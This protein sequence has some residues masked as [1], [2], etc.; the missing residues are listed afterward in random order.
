MAATDAIQAAALE[1]DAGARVR[2]APPRRRSGFRIAPILATLVL[3]LHCLSSSGQV[4]SAES[5]RLPI[6]DT[7]K[8]VIDG[9]ELFEVAGTHSYPARRR[10]S[11][12]RARIIQIAKEHAVDASTVSVAPAEGR[13]RMTVAGKPLMDIFARDI[14]LDGGPDTI[15]PE[16]FAARVRESIQRY[17][18]A[19]EPRALLMSAGYTVAATLIATLLVWFLLR[20]FGWMLPV[21]RRHYLASEKVR[22][23]ESFR[24][25]RA[26]HLWRVI[27]AAASLVRIVL[28]ALVT[29]FYLEFALGRFPWTRGVALRLF[30]LVSEPLERMGQDFI[31]YIP[32][33]V[34]LFVL[35]VITR[36]LLRGI[37]LFFRAVARQQ[38]HLA[39]F[40]ADWA[41]PTYK[42][43]R[44]LVVALAAVI[45]YPYI[46]GSGSTAFQGISI[47]FGLIVSLGASSAV[48][49]IVAGYAMTYRRAFRIGD[50]VSIGEFTGVVTD[51]RVLVTHLRTF[52]NEE[53]VVPNSQILNSHVVNYSSLA[54][55]QPLRLHTTVGI[56][57]ETPWRQVEAMLKLAAA[58]TIDALEEPPPFVLERELGDF[59]VTY[60]VNV[61]FGSATR[62]VER[63]AELHR[64]ILDVFNEY[65][66]AIMTP[67]Y[68]GDP[69]QPK[70]VPRERWH[71]APA[72][73]DPDQGA[74]GEAIAEPG[75]HPR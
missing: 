14:E 22:R 20:L 52:W 65:G 3:G 31:E 45:A 4:A 29:L 44:V 60:E 16:L 38:I 66:V 51:M 33:L 63:R 42:L 70:V 40:D 48:S 7:D 1:T 5:E 74:Q 30:D 72:A 21:V 68:E 50:R 26:E 6:V 10:A 58:R 67:A 18:A 61:H 32:S 2:S 57:Y 17:R 71:A 56:G 64:H 59:A 36:Y 54:R 9:D 15:V 62:F 75:V 8:V 55:T 23:L 69:E 34:F 37:H 25:M 27:A 47:L 46:P 49:S 53:V 35:V 11:E 39:G 43:V 19:R 73:Q 13:M 12:I 41:M 24:L 28:I